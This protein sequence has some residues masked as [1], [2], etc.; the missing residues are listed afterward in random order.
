MARK[1][2]ELEAQK[3]NVKKMAQLELFK[4][5]SNNSMRVLITAW[6]ELSEAVEECRASHCDAFFGIN[7][8]VYPL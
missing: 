5:K 1:K 8:N 2:A 3:K 4:N 7:K 6:G